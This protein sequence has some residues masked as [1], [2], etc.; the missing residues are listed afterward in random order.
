MDW[1]VA[2]GLQVLV[3]DDETDVREW[4]TTVLTECGSQVIAV[5]SVGEALAALEQFRPDVLVSDIG[6]PN[7]DGYTFIRKVRE[8][9]QNQGEHIAAIALTGYA[10]E[11]DYTQAL[12][13]GFQRHLAKP[14]K[15]SELVAVIARLAKKSEE[16]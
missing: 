9:E 7:E 10:R 1:D 14:I 13:A 15:A 8:L 12:T 4:I 5:G 16:K 6:M 11:E 2:N 3:V